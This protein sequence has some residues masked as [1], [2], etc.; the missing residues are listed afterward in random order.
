MED[1]ASKYE[2]MTSVVSSLQEKLKDNEMG[3]Q[4]GDFEGSKSRSSDEVDA[5]TFRAAF[6]EAGLDLDTFS[7]LGNDRALSVK[8]LGLLQNTTVSLNCKCCQCIYI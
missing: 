2:D 7:N 1:L 4:G 6:A 8:L 3:L 5:P